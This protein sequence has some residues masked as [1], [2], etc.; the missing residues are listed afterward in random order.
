VDVTTKLSGVS[1][2]GPDLVLSRGPRARFD[3]VVG[4]RVGVAYAEKAAGWP[5]RFAIADCPAVTQRRSLAPFLVT[6]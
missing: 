5:L 4:P 6:S 2:S 1:L 3:V